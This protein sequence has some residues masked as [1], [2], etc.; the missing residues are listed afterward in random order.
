MESRTRFR[1]L[2]YAALVAALEGPPKPLLTYEFG[3][4]KFY[5]YP[6]RRR[7]VANE[8]AEER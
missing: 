3:S 7:D 8:R 6:E 2:D 1:T 5:E 4:R